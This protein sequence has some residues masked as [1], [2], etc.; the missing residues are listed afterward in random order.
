MNISQYAEALV[1]GN[2]SRRQSLFAEAID[3]YK[4]AG[5]VSAV[6]ARYWTDSAKALR[7][8]G[9]LLSSVSHREDIKTIALYYSYLSIGG[10]ERVTAFLANLW[11]DMGYRVILITDDVAGE[12]AYRLNPQVQRCKI[13]SYSQTDAEHYHERA[14]ALSKILADKLVD[15]LVYGQ[16]L[17]QTL[18]WDMMLCKSLGID[19]LIYTHGVM[20]CMFDAD[21][22]RAE[23]A[24]SYRFADG[25]I[26]LSDVNTR[27]WRLFNTHVW[28]TINPLTILPD[29]SKRS[30]MESDTIVW[31]GRMSLFDKKPDEALKIM[32][33]VVKQCPE[34]RLLMV[35]PFTD[36]ATEHILLS[37]RKS[38]GLE[39]NVEFTGPQENVLP[40]LQE[41]SIYLATSLYEG[42]PLALAEAKTVGLPSV[43]YSLPYLTLVQ[44]QSVIQVPQGD[45][46]AAAKSIC[47]LL[48]DRNR[49]RELGDVAFSNMVAM[50]HYDFA[51]QWKEIFDSLSDE[52]A[53]ALIDDS[54]VNLMLD[55]RI[56]SARSYE[57]AIE[58]L[59]QHNA[60]LEQ[61][62]AQK[63][64]EVQYVR[65]S[66]SFKVGLLV[67]A[68]PRKIKLLVDKTRK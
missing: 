24:M 5:I 17:G 20:R 21:R 53:S 37:Q 14:D 52:S 61:V 3:K 18:P 36:E 23:L 55:A 28:Q 22:M 34:A 1:N 39:G 31:V 42:Y 40:Y 60:A 6:A 67:T 50:S 13:P 16:W 8:V 65:N 64:N 30:N 54:M 66:T 48:M 32:A 25:V 56:V 33:E 15:V 4:A 44:D 68:I 9:P 41:S 11:T 35:G 62:L 47:A 46:A 57:E 12:D 7:A 45:Y 27:F 2:L 10:A 51:Q 38:L 29:D 26:T 59:R 49:M 19:F 43:I 58:T 63:N